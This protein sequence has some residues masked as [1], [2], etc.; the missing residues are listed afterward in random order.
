MAR[1][2]HRI[3]AARSEADDAKPPHAEGQRDLVGLGFAATAAI[4][5][6]TLAISA[7]L[8]YDAGAR[9]V[10]LLVAR[11]ALTAVI[12]AV[13]H[14][15][16][17]HS[18]GLPRRELLLALGLGFGYACES[19]LF[20]LALERAPASI[21]S[22][23]FYS[24]PLW[25]N[26]LA[27]AFGL[28][29]MRWRNVLALLLG[30]AGVSLIF[31]IEGTPSTG[32]LLALAA[33]VAVAI[34]LLVAQ[35]ALR[36]VGPGIAAFWT[37]VGAA[38][39]LLV[40]AL[41]TG[42]GLPAAALPPAGGLGVATAIAFICFYEAIDRIGSAR[43]SVATMLEPVAT[44]VLAAL[45]LDEEIGARVALGALLIVAALPILAIRPRGPAAPEGP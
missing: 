17:K 28:E 31:T 5:F 1:R 8:A 11:F 20:F 16:R 37:A 3:D 24:F 33:A 13:F 19:L 42:Q 34:Y 12:L 15:V 40:A 10:P 18:L 26:V 14:L 27:V 21:V 23:V 45:I 25:T 41:V 36:S 4:A 29:R 6:G 32:M 7:K 2:P 35:V 38:A 30:T 43:T 44:V 9:P 39:T 22:L